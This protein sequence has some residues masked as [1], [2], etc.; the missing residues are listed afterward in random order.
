L[1]VTKAVRFGIRA[2]IMIALHK[3]KDCRIK[4]NQ[5]VESINV[6]ASFLENILSQ[7]SKGGLINSSTGA[8]GGY[9]LKKP[10]STI[11]ISDIFNCL[12]EEYTLV[13]CLKDENSCNNTELCRMNKFWL[14]LYK[15]IDKVF[16]NVS[17]Q[18]IINGELDF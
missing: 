8:Y 18:D 17:L 15:H 10:I 11:K 7:L 4:K 13:S 6:P 12:E 1:K 5:I 2:L 16:R 14:K 3:D 9:R